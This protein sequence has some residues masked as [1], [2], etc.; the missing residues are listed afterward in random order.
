MGTMLLGGLWHGANWT[1]VVWGGLHG[2]YLSAER[3]LRGRLAGY[4]PG[5]LATIALGLLTW[6]LVNVTWVFFRA[7]NFGTAWQVLRGMS[8]QNG[9]AKPILDTVFLVVVPLVVAGIVISHWLMRRQTLESML[10]RTHPVVVATAW[11]LMI[12]IIIIS[13]GTGNAFIYFQF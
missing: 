5:T 9:A 12:F 2:L 13:Q 7:R 4:R 8:G 10:A 11:G 3:V 1:F 6:M